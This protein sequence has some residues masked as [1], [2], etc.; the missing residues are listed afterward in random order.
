MVD[1]RYFSVGYLEVPN[2]I[3][4]D[5]SPDRHDV[6]KSSFNYVCQAET[7]Q[8]FRSSMHG[9]QFFLTFYGLQQNNPQDH[10]VHAF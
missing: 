1:A 5:P 3:K 2:T 8:R 9:Q 6:Q 4:V 7:T 10:L